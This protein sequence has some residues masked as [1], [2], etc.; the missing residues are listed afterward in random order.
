ML[1]GSSVIEYIFHVL[2]SVVGG[3]LA[4]SVIG[5]IVS[6]V[7]VAYLIRI[8]GVRLARVEPAKVVGVANSRRITDHLDHMV[9][10]D[11]ALFQ[12]LVRSRVQL[13]SLEEESLFRN[14]YRRDSLQLVL[15]ISNGDV[16][17]VSLEDDLVSVRA[18]LYFNFEYF[19][20]WLIN[21]RPSK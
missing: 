4:R 14:G 20:L 13:L 7:R 6:L 1:G 17:V 3:R 12:C 5:A 2:V 16:S 9:V 18:V 21:A 19:C 8:L 10:F 15:K 11:I